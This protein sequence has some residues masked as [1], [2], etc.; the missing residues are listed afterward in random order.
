MPDHPAR[1]QPPSPEPVPAA[2]LYRLLRRALSNDECDDA[3][4]ASIELYLQLLDRMQADLPGQE[5]H[6]PCLVATLMLAMT[7]RL[8]LAGLSPEAPG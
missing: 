2:D 7:R 8:L 4:R 1:T 6:A 5:E 3:D